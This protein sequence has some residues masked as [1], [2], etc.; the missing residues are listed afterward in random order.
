MLR[1][2]AL[3]DLEA[4]WQIRRLESVSRWLARASH[5]LDIYRDEFADP[6]SLEKS[7]AIELDPGS[8]AT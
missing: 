1:P 4:T 5:S 7:L 6:A 8:L 2:V 3:D